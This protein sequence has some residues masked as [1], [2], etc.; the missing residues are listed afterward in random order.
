MNLRYFSNKPNLETRAA[1]IWQILIGF[2]YNRQIT[3]YKKIANILD[4]NN[5]AGVLNRQLGHIMYFCK[6]NNLPPLTILVVNSETGILGDGF[7]TDLDLGRAREKVFGYNWFSI[8]T[9]SALEFSEI[10]KSYK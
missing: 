3:T 6:E 5:G 4:Y 9:P 7:E 2:A 1:Q 8:F 10:W